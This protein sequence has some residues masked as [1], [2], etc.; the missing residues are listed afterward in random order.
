[1]ADVVRDYLQSRNYA[2][3]VIRGGLDGLVRN[4]ES[5][6]ESVASGESQYRDDYLN[7]MDGRRILEEAMDVAP[8]DDKALWVERVRTADEKIRLH[9]RP[10]KECLWGEDN[11]RKY[12]YSRNRDWWYYLEPVRGLFD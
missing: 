1:M 4:W 11:A 8:D 2:E 9:L 10:T 3:P 5:V 6:A 7:D 12:G